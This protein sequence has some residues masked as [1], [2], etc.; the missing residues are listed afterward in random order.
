MYGEPVSP[1]P[2]FDPAMEKM[3]YCAERGIPPDQLPRAAGR[4]HRA[5]M[6]AG[7]IVQASAESLSGI[8]VAQLLRPGAPI[9]YG[10]RSG[11]D[12]NED[13]HLPLRRAGVQPDGRRAGP[14]RPAYRLPFFGTAAAPTPS[15][16]TP[17]PPPRWRSPA[18]RRRRS[19]PT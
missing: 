8:V 7:A 4:R 5:A 16:R 3:I 10:P 13:D 9:I 18:W 17:R 12:G 14:D 11:R 2:Y 1:L 6:L 19:A 15:C